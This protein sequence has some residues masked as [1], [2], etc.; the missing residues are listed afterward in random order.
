MAGGAIAWSVSVIGIETVA[1]LKGEKW[2]AA[3]RDRGCDRP[4]RLEIKA[5]D[6]PLFNQFKEI[7][8]SF[9]PFPAARRPLTQAFLLPKLPALLTPAFRQ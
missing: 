1:T 6:L 3:T 8:N 4:N 7:K 2:V 9:I 5:I